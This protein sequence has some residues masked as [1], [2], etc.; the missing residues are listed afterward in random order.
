MTTE[1]LEV[2]MFAQIGRA[3]IACQFYEFLFL[4]VVNQVFRQP[5]P[6]SIADVD[7][8]DHTSFRVATTALLNE[9]KKRVSV[10]SSF[11][12]RL[13]SLV[14]SR[15]VL[16]HRWFIQHGAPTT[17]EEIERLTILANTVVRDAT[18]MA[19]VLSRYTIEWGKKIPET[20][21]TFEALDSQFES[22]LKSLGS[23]LSI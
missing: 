5:M 12:D 1:E 16:I 15:H 7:P 21:A 9:L 6:S 22:V 14:D 10:D 4:Q 2:R 8:L 3:V 18:E 11:E 19:A 20:R 13:R 23:K 17:P